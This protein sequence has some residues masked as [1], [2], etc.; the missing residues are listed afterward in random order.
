MKINSNSSHLQ[1]QDGSKIGVIGG[2]PAGSFFGYFF[3]DMAERM[4]LD[5]HLDIFEPKDFSRPGSAGCNHC[6]GII[7]E[8]LVQILATE[9]LD[10]P[11]NVVQRGIDSYVM[12]TD[13]G[14]VK[15]DT[16]LHEKRIGAVYR[17]C[18]PRGLNEVKWD[19]FDGYL[20]AKAKN[21]GAN[22][23]E[24]RVDKV[25]SQNGKIQFKLAS[26]PEFLEPYDLTVVA[27]GVNSASLKLFEDLNFHYSPPK[28]SK[29]F[30]REYFLG[31]EVVEQY[32]G[33]SMH[34]FLID[35]PRFE[36]AAIIPKGESVT[37]CVLGNQIDKELIDS[38]LSM[39]ETKKCFP[40]DFQLGKG[41]CQ[42]WPGISIS[43]A[44]RPFADRIVFIGDTGTT[45]LYKDGIGAA[46]ITAKAAATTAIFQG[47]SAQDFKKYYWPVCKRI[48]L[49]NFIG[50]AIFGF[51]HS[52]QKLKF[53]RQGILRMVLAEQQKKGK[54]RTMSMVLWDM[55]TGS[56]PYR[57]IF[58]RTLNP[59]FLSRFLMNSTTSIL[60]SNKN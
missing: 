58:F 24:D 1:L 60:V 59:A 53:T 39:V 23:I 12:H 17:G 47:A 55:F 21:K 10:L 30:I 52:V 19:S 14:N 2:G 11:P 41:H 7:S 6:G 51:T 13:V 42:C 33:N 29:T 46:Y 34:V 40:P 32:L 56:A 35:L 22:V 18:G 45:R 5:V 50:K 38:F 48:K 16:P 27:T 37:I 49:D 9:G 31:K 25:N 15:I 3:L 26:S 28:T 43:S 54:K 36:F 4:G 44:Q 57:D 8:S 20:L